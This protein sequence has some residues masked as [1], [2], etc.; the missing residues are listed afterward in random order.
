MI[1]E[2]V[3]LLALG[4]WVASIIMAFFL[5]GLAFWIDIIVMC[6]LAVFIACLVFYPTW[7]YE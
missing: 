5:S 3:T 6:A 4:E 1:D 7:G 2:T